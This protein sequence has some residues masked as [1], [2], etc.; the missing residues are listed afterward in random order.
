MRRTSML[1]A[2]AAAAALV[3]G[4][5]A[6]G[7]YRREMAEIRSR[8]AAGS[9]IAAT[10]LGPI[11]YAR[12]GSGRDAFVIHGAGGGYDQG[13]MLGRALFGGD[14]AILAPSRFGYLRTPVPADSSP[15]AQADAHAAL[16]DALETEKTIVV[17]VSAGAPS[18]IEMALRHPSRVAALILI[19]PRLYCPSESVGADGSPVSQAMMRLVMSGADPGYWLAMRI[20]RP[21]LVRFLGVR[22]ELEAKAPAEERRRVTEIIRSIMPLSARL[23]GLEADGAAKIEEWPLGRIEAPTL[24]V[25]ADDDLYRTAPG[26]LYSAGRIKGAELKVLKDGGH[27]MIGRGEEVRETIRDFLARNAICNLK[28]AA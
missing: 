1:G 10:D 12:E 19:V 22:P 5:A 6:Y 2:A 16:L 3:T 18:A 4:G 13:L 21:A 27:L 15:A 9:R 8:L 25:T 7:R 11:E 17:G 26:S 28:V 23:D 20:A 24:I 14:A